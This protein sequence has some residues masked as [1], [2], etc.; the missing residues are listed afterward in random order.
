MITDF[1]IVE[2]VPSQHS[3]VIAGLASQIW[4]EHYGDL[5]QE[6]QIDYMLEKFQSEPAIKEQIERG[7]YLYYIL[8]ANGGGEERTAVGYMGVK[9]ED[10]KLFLSKFYILKSYRG[11]G[12][13]RLGFD[14]LF[15]K[16]RVAGAQSVWLTVNKGN[17]DS[18]AVYEHLG[19]IT[20]REQVADIGEGFVMDDYIMEKRLVP[21]E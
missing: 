18:I 4:R 13:G 5:L 1:L 11:K 2:A 19:F 17:R 10:N 15:E 8:Y 9:F 3:G 14:F 7:G 16:G 21:Y 6:K 20:V 12:L